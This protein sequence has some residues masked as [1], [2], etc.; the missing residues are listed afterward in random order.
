LIFKLPTIRCEFW[1]VLRC[2]CAGEL[3]CK[4]SLW[5]K[6]TTTKMA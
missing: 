3:S 1:S 4:V 5:D 6:N 2:C